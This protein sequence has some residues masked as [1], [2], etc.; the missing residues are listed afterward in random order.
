VSIAPSLPKRVRAKQGR[1][2][3]RASTESIRSWTLYQQNANTWKLVQIMAA[4]TTSATV[5]PGTYALCAV[6]NQAYESLGVVVSVK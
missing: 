6:N 1:I 3:W 5:A 2:T 4:T